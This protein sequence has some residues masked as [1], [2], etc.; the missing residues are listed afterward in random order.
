MLLFY[1]LFLYFPVKEALLQVEGLKD[2]FEQKYNMKHEEVSQKKR[3]ADNFNSAYDQWI[4][5][6]V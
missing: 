2:N 1:K 4:M 6:L 5:M 3:G